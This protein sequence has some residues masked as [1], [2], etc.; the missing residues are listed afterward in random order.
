MYIELIKDHAS[1]L[2]EGAIVAC[3][4]KMGKR[5]IA[6]ETAKESTEKDFFKYEDKR[7]KDLAKRVKSRQKEIE[8]EIIKKTK[9]LKKPSKVDPKNCENC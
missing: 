5:F 8:E 2:K 7:K 1:G 3:G 6:D 4:E 9:S